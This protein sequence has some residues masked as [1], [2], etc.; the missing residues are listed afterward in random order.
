MYRRAAFPGT[1]SLTM[2]KGVSLELGELLRLRAQAHLVK[3]GSRQLARAARAGTYRATQRGRGLEFDEVRIYQHGDDVRTIDWRVTAR[4]GRPHTKLFREERERPVLILTD[5]SAGMFFGTRKVFKSVLAMQLSALAA[6]AAEF[7][8]DRVGGVVT[9]MNG[10]REIPPRPRREGVLQLL[11][12]LEALQPRQPGE[13]R[14]G[15]LDAALERLNRVAHPGSLILIV[16]DFL[17]RGD[18]LERLLAT[19]RRHNDVLIAQISDPLEQHLPAQGRL[20]LGTPR[21][22]IVIDTNDPAIQRLWA[23]EYAQRH[24]EIETLCKRYAIPRLDV[25]TQEP[26]LQAL[27]RLIVS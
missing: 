25:Q 3:L 22:Q 8:G 20:Q 19:A 9:G 14:P 5:L 18:A 1:R 13:P 27:S 7:R 11:K 17:E 12:A 16:S 21:Q 10:H 23:T 2:S 6:W 15:Q 4:R 26:A 24:V